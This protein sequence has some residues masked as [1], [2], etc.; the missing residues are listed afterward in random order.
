M[1]DTDDGRVNLAILGEKMDNMREMLAQHIKQ[2]QNCHQDYEARLRR[3]EA[4]S[5]KQEQRL[6][7]QTGILGTLTVIGSALS[8]WLGVRN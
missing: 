7:I 3:L 8:A 2:A 6:S 1:P 5:I 4:N